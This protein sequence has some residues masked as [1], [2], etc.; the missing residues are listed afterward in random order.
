MERY[1]TGMVNVNKNIQKQYMV[2]I[3]AN[4]IEYT[5]RE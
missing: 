1:V 4:I 3:I 2:Y 5:K